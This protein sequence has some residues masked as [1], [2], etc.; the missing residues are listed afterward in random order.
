MPKLVL[1]LAALWRAVLSGAR[2]S[3]MITRTIRRLTV[4]RR[5]VRLFDADVDELRAI[6]ER[7]RH[8]SASMGAKS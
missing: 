1:A 2:A 6:G 5:R 4:D 8:R 3:Y 7:V